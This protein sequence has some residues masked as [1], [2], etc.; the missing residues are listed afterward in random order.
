V[1]STRVLSHKHTTTYLK[2]LFDA[3][4][5]TPEGLRSGI[6]HFEDAIHLDASM[7]L[8][9]QERRKHMVGARGL[10]ILPAA[11]VLPKRG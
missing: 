10:S 4:K 2:A 5:L 11:D 3:S 7:L 9:T 1:D 8:H 6:S